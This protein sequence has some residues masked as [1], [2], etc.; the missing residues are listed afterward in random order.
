M[1]KRD[2]YEVLGITRTATEVEVT[3]SYRKL[4]M[5]HHPDRNV[6]DPQAEV[7]FKEV[8]EAYEIL[9]DT[10]KRQVYDKY[11]HDGLAASSG[12]GGASSAFHDLFD[13]LLGNFFGG[14][15]GGGGRRSRGGPRAGRDIQ[16]VLDIDLVEAATGVEAVADDP[17]ARRSART[18]RGPGAKARHQAVRLPPVQRPGGGHLQPGVQSPSSRRAGRATAARARHHRPV[19]FLPRGRQGRGPADDRGRDS[20]PGSIPA[21]ASAT[22]AR[23][24]PA[25]PVPPRGDLEFV[26]RVREHKFFHRDG[27]NLVCQWPGLVPAGGPRRAD[28][29]HH[30][31]RPESH[32]R[33]PPRHPDARSPPHPRAR[34][35]EPPGAD[36]RAT[37]SCRSW[38]RRRPT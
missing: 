35:A 24:T 2:Y 5:Q 9:R 7:R 28:R 23:A 3:K 16:A 33:T 21:T 15:G 8:T 13:D 22:R 12:G 31:D 34:D 29:D 25:N 1:A 10:G 11:G 36:G 19:R 37:C 26:I 27:H 17:P 20:P 6:G 18:A 14:G 38:S 32:A 30:P 4:A